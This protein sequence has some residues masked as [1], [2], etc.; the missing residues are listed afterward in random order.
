VRILWAGEGEFFLFL[1]N[2]KKIRSKKKERKKGDFFLTAGKKCGV[3]FKF[4]SAA[5][6]GVKRGLKSNK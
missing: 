2:K 3:I 6:G 4:F 1:R 5:G